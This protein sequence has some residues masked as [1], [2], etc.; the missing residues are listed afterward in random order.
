LVDAFSHL[1]TGDPS[2]A[3]S[4][5]SAT[6]PAA[7]AVAAGPSAAAARALLAEATVRGGDPEGARRLLA[8]VP[9]PLPGGIAGA[10]LLRPAALLGDPGAHDRL[11][12][13]AARLRAPGLL[14]GVSDSVPMSN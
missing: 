9:E 12:A 3:A 13:E 7:V 11:A 2:S 1:L 10:I 5:L 6:I 4:Q 14:L 8:E